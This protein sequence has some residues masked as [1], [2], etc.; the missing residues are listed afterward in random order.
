MRAREIS[1]GG[2]FQRPDTPSLPVLVAPNDPRRDTYHRGTTRT[3]LQC[4][5]SRGPKPLDMRLPPR[6]LE[7]TT[8][9]TFRHPNRTGSTPV[10][11]LVAIKPDTPY[12]NPRT[13][14][15]VEA[16]SRGE[17][18]LPASPAQSVGVFG[19]ILFVVHLSPSIRGGTIPL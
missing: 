18:W 12:L 14:P 8:L 10:K 17:F 9:L 13:Y 7:S 15:S 4:R 11:N 16:F 3:L 1:L 5:Q 19:Y 2:G 6:V